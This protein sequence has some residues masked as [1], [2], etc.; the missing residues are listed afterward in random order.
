MLGVEDGAATREQLKNF[1]KDQE[2]ITELR[3]RLSDPSWSTIGVEIDSGDRIAVKFVRADRGTL[4]LDEIG[5]LPAAQ[6]AKLLRVVETG[7]FE[8]V[9]ASRTQQ[10]DVRILSA[11]NADLEGR[12]DTSDE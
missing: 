5:N 8:R 1:A 10:A 12:L 11:T 7:E 2:L 6:Q 9:G 4:F 3:R